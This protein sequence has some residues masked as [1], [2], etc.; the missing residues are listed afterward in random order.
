MK[1]GHVSCEEGQFKVGDG[2]PGTL[3]VYQVVTWGGHRCMEGCHSV[4]LTILG[5]LNV[6]YP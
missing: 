3:V 1:F 4:S 6:P 2:G 5:A